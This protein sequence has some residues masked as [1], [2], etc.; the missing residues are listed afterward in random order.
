MPL[1]A[2]LLLTL[3]S[4]LLGSV[5]TA[6]LLVRWRTGQDLRQVGSGNLGAT[7][8]SRVLG[9]RIGVGIYVLDMLKG[10][11]PTLCGDLLLAD[12]SGGRPTFGDSDLPLGLG[13]G[14]AAFVGHCFPVW[15][16]FRGGKG[17]ATASG[18]VLGIA[19]LAALVAIGVFVL[20]VAVAR[21][22]SLGSILAALTLPFAWWLLRE[23]PPTAEDRVILGA[24]SA[25]AAAV[26]VLHRGN[27]ARILRGEE[28]RLGRT[29]PPEGE[30]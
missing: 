1:S 14:A 11:G 27:I 21:M 22:I 26:I 10:L 24:L 2:S 18:V 3:A 6:W 8:A 16:R 17:V 29:R 25:L 12:T 4:Y 5:S 30:R 20:T 15:F 13:L 23:A 9:R 19:P 28:R 7:N